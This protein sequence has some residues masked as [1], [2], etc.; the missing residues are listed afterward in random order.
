MGTADIVPGVSGG[1]VALITGVYNELIKSISSV[2]HHLLKDLLKFDF[3][4]IYTKLNL[5]FLI[6]LG[7]GIFSALILMARLMSFLLQ[8]YGVYTWSTFFG[9]LVA[10]ILFLKKSVKDFNQPKKLATV[11]VGT[12]IGYAVVS[13]V[14]VTTPETSLFIFFSGV[15]GITAMILP[16]ISGSFILLILGKYEY[17]TS[18]L[19]NPFLAEN[20]M[21]IL[22][23]ASGCAVGIIGFSKFLN[24]L[25]KNF[26][27]KTMCVLIG[28]MIGSLKKIW[29]WKEVIEQKV[30]RGKTYVLSEANILPNEL[31][32]EVIFALIL[33]LLGFFAVFLLEKSVSK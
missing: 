8:N 21:T 23:F 22:T 7:L 4:A 27:A 15:I 5:S 19:K 16:G 2:D 33:M 28:F 17:I 26:H 10:S 6:P 11:A 32:L 25:L 9:L 29:P 24:Y 3:K 12:L 14:P 13:L 1:T 18:C 31:N 30:I 20:M